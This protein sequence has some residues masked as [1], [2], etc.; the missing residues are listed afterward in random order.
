MGAS[1]RHTQGRAH[2][3]ALVLQD[4]LELLGVWLPGKET[5]DQL[6]LI[7]HPHGHAP[8]RLK[9]LI[10]L[11]GTSGDGAS[12]FLRSFVSAAAAE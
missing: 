4:S 9:R 11:A 3:E 1:Q 7:L 2:E 5:D 6:L 8:R 12:R 10:V